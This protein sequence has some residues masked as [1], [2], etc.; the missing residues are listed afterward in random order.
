MPGMTFYQVLVPAKLRDAAG[1]VQYAMYGPFPDI[2]SASQYA[3]DKP[4]AALMLHV[5]L[6]K[7]P[8]VIARSPLTPANG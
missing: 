5:C 6:F 1:N 8:A 2:G 3:A 4:G 7:T